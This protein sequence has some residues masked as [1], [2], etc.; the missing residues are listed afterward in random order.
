MQYG[1]CR[2]FVVNAAGEKAG[3]DIIVYD[4][5][6]FPTLRALEGEDYSRKEQV[7][8]EAVYAYIEAKHTLQ[9]QGDGD[10]SAEHAITQVCRVKTLCSQRESVDT[11][12][13]GKTELSD[14]WPA[15]RNPIYGA[16]ISRQARLKKGAPVLVDAAAIR[17]A[18]VGT[19]FPQAFPPDLIVAGRC[20][21]CLPVIPNAEGS[22]F[23]C[24]VHF[25]SLQG[26]RR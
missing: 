8:I 2:G 14:C 4:R 24:Q 18:L 9:L 20:N 12:E 22:V 3:D 7:P 6:R 1:I 10:S 23:R 11:G 19:T 21:L 5:M 15:I 25:S 17:D 26:D 13:A 16:I